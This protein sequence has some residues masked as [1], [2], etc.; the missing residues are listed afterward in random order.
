MVEKRFIQRT[1][2]GIIIFWVFDIDGTIC[3]TEYKKKEGKWK[4]KNAT[5]R[6]DVI[7]KINQLYDMGE[8]ITIFTAR[9]SVFKLDWETIT[10]QQLSSWGVKYHELR[11]GKPGGDIYVDDRTITPDDFVNRWSFYQGIAASWKRQNE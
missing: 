6:Q 2:G 11:F 10:K 8:H 1:T 7:D 3:N 4:Y 5:P 9:G